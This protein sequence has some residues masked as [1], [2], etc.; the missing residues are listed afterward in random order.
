MSSAWDKAVKKAKR[1]MAK[2]AHES[3]VEIFKLKPTFPQAIIDWDHLVT[4]DF[5]TYYDDE[6]TLSKLSTSEYVRDPRFEAIMCGIKIGFGK[7]RVVRGDH[8][9]KELAKID[10]STHDL[11][12]HHAQFD[13]FILQQHYNVI[14]RRYYCTLSMARGWFSNDI[15]AGLDEVSK[16]MGRGG[17]KD[18]GEALYGMK[19]V[20]LK[21]MHPE[22]Y[23][24][25]AEYCAVD[26]DECFEIFRGMV[27][28]FPEDE[29]ALIDLT[30]QMFNC[31]VLRLDEKRIKLAHDQEVEEKRQLYMSV[32]QRSMERDRRQYI[33]HSGERR[34][35]ARC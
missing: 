17:K 25:G 4:L 20:H 27:H 33:V 14:P 13:G 21:D 35:P 28:F 23:R 24:K 32:S 7:T 16:H 6:Y 19:G 1:S 22:V 2:R 10:W 8:V 31:P 29:L 26:I 15:G 3:S 30:C 5:E 9:A 12:C 34:I 11:L 18:G